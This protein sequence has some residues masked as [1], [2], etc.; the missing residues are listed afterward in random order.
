LGGGP[1]GWIGYVLANTGTGFA[2]NSLA[3][4]IRIQTG[5][6]REF[7]QWERAASAILS[8]FAFL[9]APQNFLR[10]ANNL[11][12]F[13]K[14]LIF[15]ATNAAVQ[16]GI[17][18]SMYQYGEMT[19]PDS[20]IYG[21]NK[22]RLDQLGFSM[23]LGGA[24]GSGFTILGQL[25]KKPDDVARFVQE[26]RILNQFEERLPA[27]DEELNAARIAAQNDPENSQLQKKY[28]EVKTDYDEFKTQL[29][30]LR[31]SNS[32]YI[33][34]LIDETKKLDDFEAPDFVRSFQE[35]TGNV[36][37]DIQ[38]YLLDY[39]KLENEYAVNQ[40]VFDALNEYI[41]GKAGA[42]VGDSGIAEFAKLDTK[43]KAYV[44]A[45]RDKAEKTLKKREE[46]LG[47]LN[48][49]FNENLDAWKKAGAELNAP[50]KDS[51]A[52]DGSWQISENPTRRKPYTKASNAGKRDRSK[53]ILDVLF[54][55]RNDDKSIEELVDLNSLKKLSGGG[56]GRQG[57]EIPYTNLVIKV[58][59]NA[60]GLEQ[61]DTIGYLDYDLLDGAIAKIYAKGTNFLVVEKAVRND[62]AINKFLK[63]IKSHVSELSRLRESFQ[64]E[65]YIRKNP[66]LKKAFDDLLGEDNWSNFF[67]YGGILWGDFV[68]PSS[69]GFRGNKPILIDEGVLN[70]EVNSA[71]QPSQQYLDDFK[72]LKKPKQPARAVEDIIKWGDN[73]PMQPDKAA[74]RG[75]AP[76]VATINPDRSVILSTTTADVQ[77][78]R[79]FD[80]RSNEEKAEIVSDLI[81]RFNKSIESGEA[82]NHQEIVKNLNL[83][84]VEQFSDIHKFVKAVVESTDE[85]NLTKATDIPIP[86]LRKIQEGLAK[87]LQEGGTVD[88]L[89]ADQFMAK[90]ERLSGDLAKMQGIT[91]MLT[92][93]HLLGAMDQLDSINLN[94]PNSVAKVTDSLNRALQYVSHSRNIRSEWGRRG[95]EMQEASLLEGTLVQNKLDEVSKSLRDADSAMLKY[96]ANGEP[97][98]KEVN[99]FLKSRIHLGN[100]KN[101][102]QLMKTIEDPKEFVD[103]LIKLGGKNG[104]LQGRNQPVSLIV[105]YYANSILSAPPTQIL[106][107]LSNSVNIAFQSAARAVGASSLSVTHAG[108][109]AM[110]MME[111]NPQRALEY[112]KSSGEFK[113]VAKEYSLQFLNLMSAITMRQ[114][115]FSGVLEIATRAGRG[116]QAGLTEQTVLQDLG[117]ID[118][119][120]PYVTD[121]V[122]PL[123]EILF[124]A[125]EGMNVSVKAMGFVDEF[126]KQINVRSLLAAKNQVNFGKTLMN[127]ADENKTAF[128]VLGLSL[129]ELKKLKID[130]GDKIDL[131]AV[132]KY[133]STGLNAKMK[134]EL[135]AV[136][137]A[138]YFGRVFTPEGRF[139][140]DAE[141]KVEALKETTELNPNLMQEDPEG[142]RAFFIDNYNKKLKEY[143]DLTDELGDMGDLGNFQA[144][145]TSAEDYFKMGGMDV[146]D[147]VS[148]V[149]NAFEGI[150]N[151]L[152]KI[153][154]GGGTPLSEGMRLGLGLGAPFVRTPTNIFKEIHKTLPFSE[155]PVV[156]RI[157]GQGTYG[158]MM[159]GKF[160]PKGIRVSDPKMA[161]IRGK[162]ILGAGIWSVGHGLVNNFNQ[163]NDEGERVIIT[164]AISRNKSIVSDLSSDGFPPYSVIFVK[165]DGKGGQTLTSYSYNRL[166][167]IGAIL[168]FQADL[169]DLIHDS[170]FIVDE[171]ER[172]KSTSVIR[173]FTQAG[174]E[175][176]FNLVT[177]RN[178]LQLAE[179][180]TNA[181]R[182]TSYEVSRIASETGEGD[183]NSGLNT[184]LM[185]YQI[186][187]DIGKGFNPAI[188]RLFQKT[189]D[190][191][192]RT[193]D[194][195]F[196]GLTAELFQAL[197]SAHPVEGLKREKRRN[198]FGEPLDNTLSIASMILPSSI[199]VTKQDPTHFELLKLYASTNERLKEPH[200]RPQKFG[201]KVDLRLKKF[202]GVD[203]PQDVVD[204]IKAKNGMT[205]YSFYQDTIKDI[206]L[207]QP[208]AKKL[209]EVIRNEFG[210]V[211][212]IRAGS[213]L[214]QNMQ[215][216]FDS[217]G[218][219][220][221]K[222]KTKEVRLIGLK[223]KTKVTNALIDTYRKLALTVVADEYPWMSNA[224]RFIETYS[225]GYTNQDLGKA[226]EDF[227]QKT[228]EAIRKDREFKFED[229]TG[230]KTLQNLINN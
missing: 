151:R 62:P 211:S 128:E 8:N 136:S 220:D 161:E 50:P 36:D 93:T 28:L 124:K 99:K 171:E 2:S 47:V 27:L 131:D 189:V 40:S 160:D 178:Y 41:E 197:K 113:D 153:K 219:K 75:K 22:Y 177:N 217:V 111:R 63:P 125:R 42:K 94:D 86:A 126:T 73:P 56:S 223:D 103:T 45:I 210:F 166:D 66:E 162:A 147:P 222:D 164:G 100:L 106:G 64:Q 49:E 176:L 188:V 89:A 17:A 204:K 16:G 80:L 190:S 52:S 84:G 127:E 5:V 81:T 194:M 76:E 199:K 110:N 31:S 170:E 112:I 216:L 48:K 226:L 117:K 71:S 90:A 155:F 54:H 57:Y 157:L 116:D 143:T 97:S 33:A 196:D 203:M 149:L 35:S 212:K 83:A 208:A 138:T 107:A 183:Q 11:S 43:R 77:T 146:A 129:E 104:A 193:G 39:K 85:V 87:N 218:F 158:K 6:Q 159:S 118:N 109:A 185:G 145:L 10:N 209:N 180:M 105:E 186:G 144:K 72:N 225:S 130:L 60:K 4:D 182:L 192:Q 172:E 120:T 121:D 20:D 132:S 34:D 37:L 96:M 23:V 25:M 65:D 95:R 167:P 70:R 61:N 58:A 174:Q 115:K 169:R 88:G 44:T 224:Q 108:A 141:I 46:E 165:E 15:N 3:Q 205:P 92:S 200:P 148:S 184:L 101:E 13:K 12:K 59:K 135:L 82:L 139:K 152:V 198:V 79:P 173:A 53:R 163:Q 221:V 7:N 202:F 150:A 29:K 14:D 187:K 21:T 191:K 175:A 201:G 230:P 123:K 181:S 228:F 51:V 1:L 142:F 195:G 227:T 38:G 102:L 168:G 133:G 18:N 9:K 67:Q 119:F 32:Q 30:G 122:T 19:A 68:R 140:S 78:V 137:E 214:R 69:W 134:K 215:N 26:R 156:N 74:R 24:L 229:L 213:T 114:R 91:D 207:T 55:E 98:Q 206:R 154:S 179:S